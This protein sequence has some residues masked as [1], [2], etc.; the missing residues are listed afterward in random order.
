MPKYYVECG[1]FRIVTHAKNARGAAIWAMHRAM[2]QVLPFLSEEA[3][4]QMAAPVVLG[5][6]IK[7]NER[8]FGRGDAT[9]HDTFDVVSEWNRLLVALDKLD[10]DVS[11]E[12]TAV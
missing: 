4:S 6:L 12:T 3:V 11:S 7:T 5:E 1:N 9:V 8:G 10:E 2:G